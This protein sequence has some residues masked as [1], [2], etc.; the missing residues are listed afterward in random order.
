AGVGV[1]LVLPEQRGDVSAIARQL[2]LN[3]AFEAEGMKIS[4][5]RLVFASRRGSRS[6]LAGRRGRRF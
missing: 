6:Q 2:K 3:D 1:T 5:P 4:P